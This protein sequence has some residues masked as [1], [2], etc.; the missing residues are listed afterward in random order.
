M[1][2]DRPVVAVIGAGF[3][4][5]RVAMALRR[6]PVRVVLI[7]RRNYHL[8]QPLLYQVATAGLAA[9][10]I[11]YPVRGILRRQA[12]LQ[13]RLAEVEAVDLAG[14]RLQTSTGE[15]AYDY[16]VVACG[17]ETNYYGLTQVAEH[18]VGL[19]DLDEAVMIRNHVLRMFELAAQ[20]RDPAVRRAM[21]TFVVVGG[22]PTGV[23]SAGALSELTRLVQLRDFGE[24]EPQELRVTL[25]E[26]SNQL[27][28]GMAPS[29][30]SATAETLWRK[31]VE[32]RF[33]ATVTG[34]DGEWVTLRSGEVI[35]ARTV[36]WAAGAR[37]A[38]LAQLL[39]GPK[40]SLGR[41]AVEPT[42]QLPGHPEVY[43][44]GDAAHWEEEG[45]PLPMVAPAAVQQAGHAARNIVRAVRGDSPEP[46]TY[47]S[48]GLLA[49]I[50]RNSAVVEIGGFKS[51]GFVAWVVWLVVHLMRLV[52]FR[53]RLVV[54]I[55]WAWD[56]IF[57]DRAVRV[58][59]P[60]ARWPWTTPDDR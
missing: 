38:R 24:L 23:E 7:D 22:G 40:G 11:A 3:G 47:K 35:P 30:Q 18:A 17:A 48:P 53:N 25:L 36:V 5:L 28:K 44:I 58:I 50:G 16:L 34:F 49:T 39:D 57:Y 31:H 43:V 15:I 19:K 21:L 41:I 56:Y 33:G 13:F 2:E 45:E 42:L 12:N 6:A 26:S 46:F 4:G 37:A 20:E 51:R 27:L 1:G 55:N 10:E 52:G 32:V 29:L 14:R 8:F 9:S 59:T 54:F 60:D